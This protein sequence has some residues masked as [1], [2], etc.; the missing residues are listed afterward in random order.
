MHC[1]DALELELRVD[2]CKISRVCHIT[3]EDVLQTSLTLTV[4]V[5]H[6]ILGICKCKTTSVASLMEDTEFQKTFATIRFRDL[7]N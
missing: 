2:I 1:D 6:R 7:Q 3:L 5:R 4:S